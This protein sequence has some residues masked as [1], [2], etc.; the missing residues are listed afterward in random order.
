MNAVEARKLARKGIEDARINVL[1]CIDRMIE[2]NAKNGCKNVIVNLYS[3]R[4]MFSGWGRAIFGAP[5]DENSIRSYK[6]YLTIAGFEVNELDRETAVTN[7]SLK[8]LISWEDD[9]SSEGG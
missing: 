2:D 3:R 1:Y 4:V 9:N 6:D 5:L 8:L 7:L